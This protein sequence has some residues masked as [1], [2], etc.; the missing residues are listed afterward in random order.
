[1]PHLSLVLKQD[2]T[3][4]PLTPEQHDALFALFGPKLPSGDLID[5]AHQALGAPVMFTVLPPGSEG[6]PPENAGYA[7]MVWASGAHR[8]FRAEVSLDATP[9]EAAQI[10]RRGLLIGQALM[11]LPRLP[12]P[13]ETEQERR[14]LAA[15]KA[16]AGALADLKG[17]V[18]V[19]PQPG[20]LEP[21]DFRIGNAEVRVYD[22]VAHR[23]MATV[24]ELTLALRAGAP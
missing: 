8:A 14:E 20:R 9:A 17:P 23:L 6:P 16:L 22:G 21:V 13:V 5:L 11:G 10:I 24:A 2:T 18:Q 1:M 3:A 7:V 15:V 12:A 4:P 19:P